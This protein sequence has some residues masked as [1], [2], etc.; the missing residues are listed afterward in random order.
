VWNTNGQQHLKRVLSK[1]FRKA[2]LGKMA[3]MFVDL[4]AKSAHNIATIF[5]VMYIKVQRLVKA[6]YIFGIYH[7][8]GVPSTFFVIVMKTRP[9]PCT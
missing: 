5:G 7:G 9:N 2:D 6:I 4:V 8:D 3:F 1:R